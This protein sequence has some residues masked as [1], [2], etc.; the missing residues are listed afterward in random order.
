MTTDNNGVKPLIAQKS[1]ISLLQS[2]FPDQRIDSTEHGQYG[3]YEDPHWIMLEGSANDEK[4]ILKLYERR[5]NDAE[6][7]ALNAKCIARHEADNDTEALR[8][9]LAMSIFYFPKITDHLVKNLSAFAKG[10][11]I[12]PYERFKYFTGN[13]PMPLSWETDAE[14]EAAKKRGNAGII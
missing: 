1:F 6:S 11:T 8:I 7:T 4:T 3:F 2:I 14:L 9:F 12:K 5:F 13:L 10:E